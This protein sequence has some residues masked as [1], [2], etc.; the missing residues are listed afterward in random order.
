[1]VPILE[2]QSWKQQEYVDPDDG[3]IT[4]GD[5]HVWVGNPEILRGGGG[6]RD[7]DMVGLGRRMREDH[8]KEREGCSSSPADS[9]LGCMAV[10]YGDKDAMLNEEICNLIY[11]VMCR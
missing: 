6:W 3:S 9:E 8:S 5:D 2:S 10:Q 1:M 4:D 11:S 7:F